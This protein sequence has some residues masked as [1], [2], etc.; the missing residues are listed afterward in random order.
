LAVSATLVLEVITASMALIPNPCEV[1][2][3]LARG[4]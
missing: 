3:D 2:L 4:R 1:G